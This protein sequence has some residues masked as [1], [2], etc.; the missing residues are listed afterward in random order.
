MA[1]NEVAPSDTPQ[2]PL[3][4]PASSSR[5][6]SGTSSFGARWGSQVLE[7]ARQS[8]G[9]NLAAWRRCVSSQCSRSQRSGSSETSLY[10]Y[11]S[12]KY[13]L[14]LHGIPSLIEASRRHKR[15]NRQIRR[16]NQQ[17]N[18]RIRTI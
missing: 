3:S 6:F 4:T 7:E 16:T 13:R 1:D 9:T 10:G 2:S 17:A 15:E 14:R 8:S 12:R 5:R 18:W 11:S